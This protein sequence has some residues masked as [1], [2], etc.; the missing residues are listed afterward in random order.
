[1]S[2][3]KVYLIAGEPS[4]DLLGARLMRALKKQT[5]GEVRFFGVGGEAMEAEGMHSLFDISDLSVMGIMEVIPSI[6]KILRHLDEI[7]ADIQ[8]IKPDIVM[9][10]DSYSFSARVHQRLKQAGYERPHVHCVAPQVW[11]WKKGRAKKIGQ[12]V[13]HLFCL[14]PNEK[15]YFEPYGTK[16]TFIGHPVVEGGADK[17]DGEA[18]KKKH[19]IPPFAKVL[20]VLPGSRKN[21]IKYLLPV[22]RESAELL[23]SYVPQ[24]FVIV[25]TVATVADRIKKELAGWP[26]PHVIVTGEKERYDAFAASDVALAASGTV[27]VELAMAGVPHLI[28]YKVSP[29]TGIIAR[30]LLKIRFVNLLN[31]M[32]DKEVIPE[33]LQEDC[34]VD[35]VVETLRGLL[36]HPEQA[37]RES[38]EKLG[39]GDPHAPSDKLAEELQKL[40]RRGERSGKRRE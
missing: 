14:L 9:T 2:E 40:A 27:S 16:A 31:L 23:Q 26:V 29:L 28:A 11:A 4:G 33:L 34:T 21:E 12:F 6:P 17:G 37:T 39:L 24:L 18:F 30:K 8:A 3:L 7:V 25:P 36:A 10:I 32:V 20:C 22:F 13:D 1:M 15:D 35:N 38:L 5:K 19:G